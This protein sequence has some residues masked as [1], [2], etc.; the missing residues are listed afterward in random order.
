LSCA[1]VLASKMNISDTEIEIARPSG[2]Q[3][4]AGERI[5]SLVYALLGCPLGGHLALKTAQALGITV[6]LTLRSRADEVIE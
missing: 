2:H 4:R 1:L 3:V 5:S 6:P